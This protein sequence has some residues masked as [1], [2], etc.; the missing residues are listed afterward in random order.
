L[1]TIFERRRPRKYKPATTAIKPGIITKCKKFGRYPINVAYMI[2]ARK[3]IK[4][5][6]AKT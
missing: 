6:F 3:Q 5:S 1:A 2:G 4:L